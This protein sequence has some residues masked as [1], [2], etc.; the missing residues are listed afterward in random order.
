MVLH[1]VPQYKFPHIRFSQVFW[2]VMKG[3]MIL[4]VGEGNTSE[5]HTYH[6]YGLRRAL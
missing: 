2:I 3:E 1:G 4:K 6:N 5:V